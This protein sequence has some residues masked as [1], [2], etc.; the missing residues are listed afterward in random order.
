MIGFQIGSVCLA[1]LASCNGRFYFTLSNLALCFALKRGTGHEENAA[2][3][4]LRWIKNIIAWKERRSVKISGHV[5]YEYI[6]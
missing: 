1:L 3:I 6:D 4:I 2:L 5:F